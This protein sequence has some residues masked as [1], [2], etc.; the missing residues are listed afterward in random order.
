M[1]VQHG[2]EHGQAVLIQAQGN[3]ARIGHMAGVDQRLHFHQHRSGALPGGHHHTAGDFLLGA[4]EEDRRRVGDLFQALVGHAE[5]AQFVDRAK[6]VLYRPQQ[7]Q[8]AIGLALEIQHGVD[9]MFEYPRTGQRTLLG[10]MADQEDRR[11]ALLGEAHQQRRALAHLGY[12]AGGRGQLF[13]EDGLD[14]V[15]HHHLGFLQTRGGDD[16]FDAGFGHDLE[17]VFRQA[18]AARTH[19]HLLLGFL[20]GD[21]ERGKARGDIAQGLQ[22]DGRFAD[23]GVTADQHHRA[24]HQA[25]AEHPVEFA[26]GGGKARYFF[27]ADLGQGLDLRLLA[28]PPRAPAGSSGIGFEQGFHQGV[29]GPA[30]AALAGPFGKGRAALGAAVHTFGLGHAGLLGKLSPDDTK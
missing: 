25:T 27:D 26:G 29:P 16:A 24:V 7:T 8:T 2:Q 19:G 22:Q 3:A 21:I 15:D 1:P 5:H 23:A 9:H 12:A 30:L 6:A 17:L 10:H 18:Q 11:A 4:G 14:R 13:G 20:A 28:G